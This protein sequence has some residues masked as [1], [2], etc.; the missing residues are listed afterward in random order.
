[1]KVAM[2]DLLTQVPFYDR[3]LVEALSPLIN[4]LTLYAIQFRHEPGYLDRETF[5]RSPGLIDWRGKRQFLGQTL[6]WASKAAEYTMNWV[7]L[8]YRF[9]H[10]P[11]DVVHI[12]WLPL[13]PRVRWE[14][15]GIKY[16]QRLDIPVIYTVHN[17][18]PHD[19]QP[20][21]RDVYQYL[22]WSVD[23]LIVHTETDRQRL[24]NDFN[25]PDGKITVISHGPLFFEQSGYNQEKAQANLGVDCDS[26]VFLM[27]GVIRPYKGVEETIRAL[28]RV[29]EEGYDCILIVA[30]NVL[31]DDYLQRLRLLAA[32]LGVEPNIRWFLGYI[33]S[34]QIGIFHAAADVVLFPYKDISQSGAFLT[35]AG[36][37]KCTLSAS[38]GGLAEVV[39]DGENGVQISSATPDIIAT[40]LRI[41]LELSSDRREALGKSLQNYVFKHYGWDLIAEETVKVYRKLCDGKHICD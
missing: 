35:A 10:H 2:I 36:L 29:I 41:C 40:G 19:A 16:L 39:V 12:Q 25:V 38:T 23:H 9:H 21:L 32:E 20:G 6:R 30:G 18:L 1:M 5:D 27:L 3:Y 8:L 15:W 31:D 28:A 7:S 4:D 24:T 26:F 14:L 13:L 33:P 34:D 11:P 17:Y 37:G 22:Y